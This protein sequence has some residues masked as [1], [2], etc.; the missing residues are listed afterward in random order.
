MIL[1]GNICCGLGNY[2]VPLARNKQRQATQKIE[3][4]RHQGGF[5]DG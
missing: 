1:K 2:R 4:G 3:A 5:V